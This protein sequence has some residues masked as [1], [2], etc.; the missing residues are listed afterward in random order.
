MQF[1][2]AKAV[3]LSVVTKILQFFKS[4]AKHCK[5]NC[6]ALSSNVLIYKF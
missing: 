5:L 6:T 3:V 1:T 2:Q 4:F